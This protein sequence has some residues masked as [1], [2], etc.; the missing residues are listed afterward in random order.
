[1]KLTSKIVVILLIFW[2]F[3]LSGYI[4]LYDWVVKPTLSQFERELAINELERFQKSFE[5]DLLYLNRTCA[6]YSWWDDTYEFVIN[7]NE[8]FKRINLLP[9]TYKENNIN[10]IL[11][12]N[13]LGE[14]VYGEWYNLDKK[15]KEK[16]PTEFSMPKIAL[17][18]PLLTF[19]NPKSGKYGI[20]STNY[21]NVAVASNPILKSNLEG[22]PRGVFIMGK[23]LDDDFWENIKNQIM[24]DISIFPYIEKDKLIRNALNYPINERKTIQIYESKDGKLFLWDII[25]DIYGHP[26]ILIR[27]THNQNILSLSE[28]MQIQGVTGFILIMV[29]G[30]IS[31]WIAIKKQII[32]PLQDLTQNIRNSTYRESITFLPTIEKNDEIALLIVHF[33]RMAYKINKLLEEKSK[34]VK[35]IAERERYLRFIIN[36]VPCVIVEFDNN[37]TIRTTNSAIKEIVGLSP[38]EVENRNI[39]DIFSTKSIYDFLKQIKE[40][41]EKTNHFEFEESVCINDKKKYL[42]IYFNKNKRNGEV[43]CIGVIW[44]ITVLREIQEKYN[45]QKQ[46]AI[47]GEAS[48][49]LA[50]ELRNMITAIQSGFELMR[51]EKNVRQREEITSELYVSIARLE[52]TLRKLLEFTK[53]YKLQKIE[54]SIKELIEEQFKQCIIQYNNA[55]F[56]EFNIKGDAIIKVD[57]NL[58]SRAIIN[59]LNNSIESISNQGKIYVE[60]Y[61]KNDSHYIE[62]KD[63]GIGIEKENLGKIGKPFFT[64]KAKGTGLGL[65]ITKKII[66]SHGGKIEIQSEKGVGTNVLIILPLEKG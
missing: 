5:K 27:L 40:N 9:Q 39:G 3:L 65:T 49:S 20:I 54:V 15:Q 22:E 7:K 2:I 56:I 60:I 33:N 12:I 28:S 10:M 23:L 52:E 63:N 13:A 53:K 25:N 41:K 21:G 34:L 31:L 36:S 42:H 62:I 46:L 8:N 30:I 37:G 58:F 26:I 1:M 4:F 16:L 59:I 32:S 11:I 57:V 24:L 14:V 64:T 66:E 29:F 38:Q 35:E 19:D 18:H 48:A 6:D 17:T 47:L 51:V 45:E 44:D 55:S 61:D 50:H 43:F